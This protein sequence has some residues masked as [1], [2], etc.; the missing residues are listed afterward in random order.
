MSEDQ[1][2]A[3]TNG[4][5]LTKAE[6]L[7]VRPA[8]RRFKIIDLTPVS[9]MRF[10]IVSLTAGEFATHER[11]MFSS[12]GRVIMARVEDAVERLIV[13]C[14]VDE[15]GNRLMTRADVQNIK[16]KWDAADTQHVYE[17]CALH[18]GVDA[19]EMDAVRKNLQGTPASS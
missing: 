11:Q 5:K 6:D 1:S 3:T 13:L 19:E 4:S 10:R 14:V 8:K 17:Q 12:K 15:N 16:D 7:F 9:Q 18:I 2:P